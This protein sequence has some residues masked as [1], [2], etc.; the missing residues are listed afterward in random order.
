MMQ[1]E[2]KTPG[3]EREEVQ[4]ESELVVVGERTGDVG[5]ESWYQS[6]SW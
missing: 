3:K 6:L 2:A 5:W 4:K 1:N